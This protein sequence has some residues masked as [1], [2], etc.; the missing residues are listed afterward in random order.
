MPSIIR[1]I[2]YFLFPK[3]E[4]T[5]P[6]KSIKLVSNNNQLTFFEIVVSFSYVPANFTAG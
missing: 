3:D 4:R 5:S 1:K 6:K 2:E